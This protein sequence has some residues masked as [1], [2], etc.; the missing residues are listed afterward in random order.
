MPSIATRMVPRV[1]VAAASL[2]TFALTEGDRDAADEP[3]IRAVQAGPLAGARDCGSRP[4]SLRPRAGA[5]LSKTSRSESERRFD[6]DDSVALPRR[7]P[8]FI[9]AGAG[10]LASCVQLAKELLHS[11]SGCE[12]HHQATRST[13]D[14]SGCPLRSRGGSQPDSSS[15]CLPNALGHAL[16]RLIPRLQHDERRQDAGGRE[17]GPTRE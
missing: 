2:A 17:N 15:E 12:S 13:A 7:L 5:A 3:M 11:S 16:T 9:G 4:R 14:A 10:V 8:V 1:D 6:V